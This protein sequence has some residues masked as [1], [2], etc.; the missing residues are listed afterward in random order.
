MCQ[1]QMYSK[2]NQLY[3]YIHISTLF[4][5]LSPG[6]PLQSSEQSSLCY[7]IGTHQLP[8][9]YIAVYIC[10]SQPPSLFFPLLPT[11]NLKFAFYICNSISVLQVSSFVSLFQISQ[12][13]DII[14]L[15]SSNRKKESKMTVAE[16]QRREKPT[17]IEQRK[18]QGLE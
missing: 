6:R 11:G 5:I 4:Q 2:V 16:G 12:I 17:K 14:L 8:T 7:T 10:Q 1:I 18:V 13:S 15:G 3:I 9:L